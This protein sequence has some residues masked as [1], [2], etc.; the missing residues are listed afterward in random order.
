MEEKNIT[1]LINLLLLLFSFALLIIPMFKELRKKKEIKNTK[2]KI[3]RTESYGLSGYGIAIITIFIVNVSVG[4][5]KTLKDVKDENRRNGQ[6]I[7]IDSLQG[8]MNI[9]LDSSERT[10]R[11]LKEQLKTAADHL[12]KQFIRDSTINDK[13]IQRFEAILKKNTLRQDS[14]YKFEGIRITGNSFNSSTIGIQI[15]NP[16]T[17]KKTLKK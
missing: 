16:G 5:Y 2:G 8:I 1:V 15:T 10:S 14:D 3:I 6:I 4:S 7:N 17:L 11:K 9:K 12:I 13:N